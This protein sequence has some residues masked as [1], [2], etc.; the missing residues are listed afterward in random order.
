MGKASHLCERRF[1]IYSMKQGFKG[2]WRW[3]LFGQWTLHESFICTILYLLI[4][5]VNIDS[6]RP[7]FEI[8]EI[9]TMLPQSQLFVMKW[10]QK[11][12]NQPASAIIYKGVVDWRVFLLALLY[13]T[14]TS[15]SI[16]VVQRSRR[17]YGV[18]ETIMTA[19]ALCLK[20]M[21]TVWRVMLI[22]PDKQT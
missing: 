18:T 3:H 17:K 6:Y 16:F 15:L 9:E 13:V 22:V 10:C 21:M 1:E 12:I 2:F 7:A 8:F 4:N 14:K 11:K 5:K 20:A 19:A